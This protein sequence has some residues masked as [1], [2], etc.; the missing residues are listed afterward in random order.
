MQRVKFSLACLLCVSWVTSVSAQAE[1]ESDSG[2]AAL[3]DFS[4]GVS[5]GSG[6]YFNIQHLSGPGVGYT[7]GY[8]N[9]GAFV[10]YWVD[11]DTMIAPNGRMWFTNNSTVGGS[12]GG[13]FRRYFENQDRIY[14]FNLY[15]DFD[16]TSGVRS[17]NYNQFGFGFE[18]LGQYFDMRSNVYLPQTSS[19]N[20]VQAVSLGSTPVYSGNGINFIGVGQFQEALRGADFEVGVP[21]SQSTPWLRTYAG[22]YAYSATGA[23]PVGVRA[24]LEA[25]V[26]N[27]LTIGVNVTDDNRFGT[28][29]NAVVDFRFSGFQPTR[30]FP[31]LTTRDRMLN[32][33]QRNGRISTAEFTRNV[34]VQ[35]INPG[36]GLPYFAVWVDNSNPLPGNGTFENPYHDFQPSQPYPGADLILVRRGVSDVTP[37]NGPVQLFDNQRLLGEGRAHQIVA[38]AQF[39]QLHGEGTYNLPGFFNNGLYPTIT[40][41][42]DIITI[43]N[44]NEVSGFN[45]I[46]AGGSAITNNPLI[47]SH[48]FNINCVDMINNQ[49]GIFLQNTSGIG[50]ISGSN[51][52][53]NA[54][55]G[56]AVVNNGPL[57]LLIQD[58]TSNSS[59]PATQSVGIELTAS[60]APLTVTMNNVSTIG[61]AAG[62]RINALNSDV[63][64]I[65]NTVNASQNAGP[66][67]QAFIDGGS[68]AMAA[69]SLNASGNLQDN[70]NLQ[71]TNGARM[72]LVFSNVDASGS[73]AG[74]GIV[75]L[76]NGGFGTAFLDVVNA[77]GNAG[78]G[79]VLQG[80]NAANIQVGISGNTLLNNNAQ[81]AIQ[82]G[83]NNL[84]IVQ[85]SA[86]NVNATGSGTDGL[87][88]T[89][90]G[91]S[92]LNLNFDTVQLDNSGLSTGANGILGINFDSTVN[93]VFN[94]VTSN[95]NGG[96]GLFLLSV[97]GNNDI[98]IN[99]GSFSNNGQFATNSAGIDIFATNASNVLLNVASVQ[100]NND[101]S[102][103]PTQA[104][105]LRI[106]SN[107]ASNITANLDAVDL[108]SNLDNAVDAT[109]ATN[110][111]ATI[112]LVNTDASSSGFSGL[113]IDAQS[114][115]QLQVFADA[116]P[117]NFSGANGI[118][119][120]VRSDADVLV[121]FSNGSDI[122][123]S[124]QNGVMV[125]IADA[126]STFVGQF[127]DVNVSESGF[128]GGGLDTQDAFHVVA[129]DQAQVDL[130][131]VNTPTTNFFLN[132]QQR[133][134]FASLQ[135]GAVLNFN[136]TNGDMSFNT[137][138]AIAV[139][140]ANPGS[141]ANLNIQGTPMNNSGETGFLWFVSDSGTVNATINNSSLDSSGAGGVQG[142][143]IFGVATTGGMVNL[144]VSNTP[145]TN[146]LDDAVF[147]VATDLGT[148][149]NAT[150]NASPLDNAGQSALDL[151]FYNGAAG[152]FTLLNGSTGINA[153]LDAVHMI[154]DGVAGGVNT[155]L[156]LNAFDSNFSDS[157]Q[158]APSNGINIMVSQNANAALNII[159]TP[160]TNTAGTSPQL[161]G[162]L[163]SVLSGGNLEANFFNSNLSNHGL[164][165]INGTVDGFNLSDSRALIVLDNT[166]VDGN[167]LNGALFNVTNRGDLVV[168]AQNGTS[169]ANNG[170]T[171]IQANVDGALST[172]SFV[173]DTVS[174][175]GNGALVGGDGMQVNATNA[176]A[177]SI[178]ADNSSFSN[179]ANRGIALLTTTAA[180]GFAR[181]NNATVNNNN[182]EALSVEANTA[183]TLRTVVIG[184]SLSD[185]GLG[186]NFNNVTVLS[187]QSS[188]VET[189]FEN[190]TAD[191]ST[192]N[193]F[194]FDV[195]SG[196][197]LLSQMRGGVTGND[198]ANGSGLRFIA[199]DALTQGVL[200]MEGDNT[201]D[202][203]GTA[204]VGTALN[205]QAG[206]GVFFD[207]NGVD[208]A[209]IAFAG[210]ANSNGNAANL[211][212]DV[213]A[214]GDRDD[215]G[216]Y[217]NIRN[218]N[219]AAVELN[220]PGSVGSN[221]GDGVDIML[222]NVTTVGQ[223][224][225][226]S[227]V[228][229]PNVTLGGNGVQINNLT[230]SGNAGKGVSLVINNAAVPGPIVV[231]GNLIVQNPGGDGL[232][233]DLTNVTGTP[234]I[235][236]TNN[237]IGLNSDN[238]INLNLN[239]APIDQLNIVG[240]SIG[241]TQGGA[242][243]LDDTLPVIRAGFDSIILPRNDDQS[244]GVT[245]VGFNLNFFG[246]VFSNLFV[247]NNGNVTFNAPLF[248]FTPFPIVTNGIPI[249]APF[250]A[251]VDTLTNGNPTVYGNSTVAGRPAFGVTWD[252][253]DY[254]TGNHGNQ[255][256]DFQLVIIER[257]D[258]APGDFD[259]EFNYEKVTWETGDASSGVNG[260]GG[261]SARVGFSNGST[262]SLEF[263]GSAVNGAFLDSGPAATSLI[264]N[265]LNSVN[266]GRYRFASR[267]GAIG[268]TSPNGGDGIRI[269]ATN[270][271]DIAN[272]FIDQNTIQDNGGHGVE[273]LANNINL[274]P[275][276]ADNNSITGNGGD[277]IRLVS[278][279]T[280]NDPLNIFVNTNT[281]SDN[282]GTGVNLDLVAGGQ[283]LNLQNNNNTI[284]RNTGGPGVNIALADNNNVVANFNANNINSN[285]AE[286]VNFAPG[287][288]GQITA[289][290]TNNT[291]NGNGS[292]GIDIPLQ[293]GGRFTS[294][295][296][297]GNTIGTAA[298]RNGGMGV[299]LV[300]PNNAQFAWQ[301]GDS[302]VAANS[303][304]GNTDA[305]VG[306][307]L[308][309]NATGTLN[310]E[311]S[312]FS[313][314]QAGG[315][316]IF[317]GAGLGINQTDTTV[318]NNV[319]IGDA[320]V[321]NTSFNSNAGDGLRW[322][323]AANAQLTNPIIRN[324][325]ANANT[326]D[327]ANF[328][329][330][331]NGVVDNV[332]INNSI[333]TANSDGL[334]IGAQFAM[335][336]DEY[337]ITNNTF[338]ANNAN[339]IRM[340]AQADAQINTILTN[341]TITNNG[342]DGVNISTVAISPGDVALVFSGLGAWTNNTFDTNGRL[343][344]SAGAGIEI[345]GIHNITLG[346]GAS[347]NF[348]RNNAGDG[349]EINASGTLIVNN[350][351][352][353]GNVTEGTGDGRAGID[354]NSPGG[355]TLI[356]LASVISNNQGDGLE[357][358][359]TGSGT[360]VSINDSAIQFNNRDGVEWMDHGIGFNQLNV[361]GSAVGSN[362][363][364]DNG[365]RGLDIEVAGFNPT[366]MVSINQTDILRNGQEGVYVVLSSDTNQT[367][368]AARDALASAAL[369]AN[370]AIGATPFLTFGL[371][372][373]RVN[374]NGQVPGTF[375][376]SGLVVR[377]GTTRGGDNF[378]QQG[379][380]A[381]NG[382]G[383]V[384]ANVLNNT[385]MTGNFGA[386]VIF[387][388][389]TSTVNPSTTAGAWT[390]QNENPRNGA[391]DVFA[392]ANFQSDPL[393]RLDLVF[394]NNTGDELSVTRQ[395]AAY[396][397]DEAV[398]KSR[399]QNQDNNTDGGPDDDGPFGS[400]S[401]SRNAQ[402]LAA[403]NVD[404]FLNAGQKL[405]PDL[406][407]GASDSFLFSGLGQS[408]F[409]VNQAGN[410]F[411][412]T[413]PGGNFI[414]DNFA[415]DPFGNNAIYDS[416]FEARGT[417]GG[418][419]GGGDGGPFGIDIMPWGW[420]N[421]P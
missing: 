247:N 117:F 381:T 276:N 302:A 395:G 390:D 135:T 406:T 333:F 289:N 4:G 383:G 86:A 246:T 240:N 10:P 204:V 98:R 92:V 343:N 70:I 134:L 268:G 205:P 6:T 318:L 155:S 368:A 214:D 283:S 97:N 353:T 111:T 124:G 170:G 419:V 58:V 248:S 20:F 201:F 326:G 218:T 94:N 305:G 321:N 250:F 61:N 184:G 226:P 335:L 28:N 165:G 99:G 119:A 177:F 258:V 317:G 344:G 332:T 370:G 118:D 200:Y 260:L 340:N 63:V 120:F 87:F 362:I 15:G 222:T 235:F 364:S 30:Y 106:S 7:S 245:P 404:V 391:N 284:E 396:N 337:T 256:N 386:D 89:A 186:G 140:V 49:R 114:G 131:L 113:R 306:I 273:I 203:N 115:G 8:T 361:N 349:I 182:E 271:S 300:V 251:D 88:F 330:T 228:T 301:V 38:S 356:V 216:I 211:F 399:T 54:L 294:D 173:L 195:N 37:L 55:G 85:L 254:F 191:N 121:S 189:Y 288:N 325:T 188:I 198:N 158:V 415:G 309:G 168:F 132:S 417:G 141:V 374:Q 239:N 420:A 324:V 328:L 281:I 231:S 319:T 388:S 24:R 169:F 36:T 219:L 146:A 193:G 174:V 354:L 160:I 79:F 266:L 236:I 32:P 314:T 102:V 267:G 164:E 215:D 280:T 57:N 257:S 22:L 290:F 147:V 3:Q 304:G 238:G 338:N 190:V 237:Q 378:N 148:T 192:L 243:F 33:V 19:G 35:A 287:L 14:G 12:I 345:S 421:L 350:D 176:G 196:S 183:S 259:F 144:D 320:T 181:F 41:P 253:V 199:R 315:A 244:S 23:D 307:R 282:G 384:V 394:Q 50:V 46:N 313:N 392:P 286:G 311:N 351:V 187:T 103:P 43:A 372:N 44:N 233:I 65:F 107:F 45:L 336:V 312:S 150:F 136:N 157:G 209:G 387:Q 261:S 359:I 145:I 166:P 142:S 403:R 5:L 175:D 342:Q 171:G 138:N 339:G 48:N 270:G 180:G 112:N 275:I 365:F 382:N 230:V 161:R 408:T 18:S 416:F 93:A 76:N 21:V 96:D 206:A 355:N 380:F 84:S 125:D 81:H 202:T 360:L 194:S 73:V 126:G 179:N 154:A 52:L 327:G 53:D 393:A 105:G 78:S 40:A 413:A 185:N 167:V 331:G 376:G 207:A 269:N 95:G 213:D 39:E 129:T 128:A 358:D 310:I 11:Q 293:T 264:Q 143:G 265:S 127:N 389:F 402:R 139:A 348:I 130:N 329:R 298:A 418:G 26:S 412:N 385:Q 377:V 357:L 278:P 67:L 152:I 17:Y 224:I 123:F 109:V 407:I 51:A 322:R 414:L 2:V 299:N 277:G 122:L 249:I 227:F 80:D 297:Y 71:F 279:I 137:M 225:Q 104:D 172:A 59:L 1:L 292:H 220:G 234:D 100:V 242:G 410:T 116:S 366:S 379:G 210:G 90:T 308:S 178:L 221:Q 255:T 163:F 156:T 400:G 16:Q 69:N 82:V 323:I 72:D 397:N 27:D 91:N 31:Q 352:I 229:P 34:P 110:G 25:T 62:T 334:D 108:T 409:R 101:F 197:I 296:F 371:G 47:G 262:N 74:N 274:G 162:L 60:N 29:V 232:L 77:A 208:R 83:A 223:I 363:I 212:A 398:F 217:I 56:I 263:A 13:V 68:L 411:V 153:G 252:N 369:P 66:G 285:G 303:I 9:I 405:N 316:N 75:I 241:L 341:N 401:R 149:V 272:T 373:S 347:G 295:N 64:A 133:G 159:N 291:I 367:G 42:G 346:T 151:A 375:G